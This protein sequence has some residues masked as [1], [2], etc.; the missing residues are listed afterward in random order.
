M[1]ILAPDAEDAGRYLDMGYTMVGLGSD[2]ELLAR[3]AD[4][5]AQRFRASAA[6]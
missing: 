2:L 4:A 1:G 5:L 6:E 3:S